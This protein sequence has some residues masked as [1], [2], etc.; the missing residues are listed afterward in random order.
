MPQTIILSP[1]FYLCRSLDGFGVTITFCYRP[2]LLFFV[3]WT[4]LCTCGC[5]CPSMQR[6]E[7]DAGPLVL[8]SE[9]RFLTE[10]LTGNFSQAGCWPRGFPGPTWLHLRRLWLWTLTTMLSFRALEIWTQVPLLWQ[11]EL[12]TAEPSPANRFF[13]FFLI[14][15]F[16]LC[17]CFQFWV[18]LEEYVTKRQIKQNNVWWSLFLCSC[19]DCWRFFL[20]VDV[21]LIWKGFSHLAGFIP[22]GTSLQFSLSAFRA[23]HLYCLCWIGKHITCHDCEEKFASHLQCPNVWS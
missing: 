4:S 21:A 10:P 6:L 2:S 17:V 5:W 8:V 20:T 16:C 15:F 13:F 9:T 1:T 19:S 23:K 7:Q 14:L 12:L 3:W 18:I 22:T 11:Q